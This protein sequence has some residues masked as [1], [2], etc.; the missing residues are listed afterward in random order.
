MLNFSIANAAQCASHRVW[1]G[2]GWRGEEWLL[3]KILEFKDWEAVEGHLKILS[4]DD[5]YFC[6]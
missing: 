2:E 1:Q 3:V 6:F 4:V 5:R